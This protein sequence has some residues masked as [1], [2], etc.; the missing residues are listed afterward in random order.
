MTNDLY[1]GRGW[2]RVG[3]WVGASA[4]VA[5]N[6]AHAFIAR[7][8][9]WLMVVFAVLPPFAL[10]V[11]VE[12]ISQVAWR[13][14]WYQ[15]MIRWVAVGSVAG[16]GGVVSFDHMRSALEH[17]GEK[18]IGA[19]LLPLMIDGLMTVCSAALLTIGDNVRRAE[20]LAESQPEIPPVQTPAQT[21]PVPA[22]TPAEVQVKPAKPKA[23]RA[24]QKLPAKASGP[25]R[26]AG[27]TKALV[28]EALNGDPVPTKA[29]I[30]AQAGVSTRRVYE[31]LA[32]E[33]A[34]SVNG[35]VPNLVN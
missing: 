16:I 34:P 9:S 21:L 29:E 33:N 22:E 14:V 4:S 18:G 1:R 2:A 15:W 7:D 11:G 5:A 27:Q 28:Q 19:V 25:R 31:I 17:H 32:D 12:V 13:P 35:N 30:A 23:P 26:P 10:L 24:A 6:V 8:P 20:R 3:F